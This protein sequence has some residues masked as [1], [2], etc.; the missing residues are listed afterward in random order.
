MWVSVAE[1]QGPMIM[2]FKLQS[3]WMFEWMANWEVPKKGTG[4]CLF[5]VK[6]CMSEKFQNCGGI[7]ARER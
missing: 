7:G 5:Y 6:I 2:D 1:K 4:T 3:I